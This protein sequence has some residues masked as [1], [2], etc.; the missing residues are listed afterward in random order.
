MFRKL[1]SRDPMPTN[2]LGAVAPGVEYAA[3]RPVLSRQRRQTAQIPSGGP[4][5]GGGGNGW[6]G[7]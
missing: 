3:R 1:L 4:V 5:Q 2:L 7:G 6:L